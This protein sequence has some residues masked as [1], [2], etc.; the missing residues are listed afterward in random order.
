MSTRAGSAMLRMRIHL[1]TGHIYE[2]QVPDG[3]NFP[4]QIAAIKA[5]GHYVDQS[6]FIPVDSIDFAYMTND[7]QA[8]LI[9]NPVAGMTKQ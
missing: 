1:R 9:L 8:P 7:G 4:I 3:F 2:C 6:V 5:N